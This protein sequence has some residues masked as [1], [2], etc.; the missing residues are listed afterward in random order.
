MTGGKALQAL[1]RVRRRMDVHAMVGKS[2]M[3]CWPIR[4]R[5][6]KPP[7]PIVLAD[8]DWACGSASLAASSSMV[9]VEQ[10]TDPLNNQLKTC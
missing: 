7:L 8:A 2:Q 5:H 1:N 9:L 3:L 6:G 10:I 4:L